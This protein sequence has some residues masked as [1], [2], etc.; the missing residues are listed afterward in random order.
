[1]AVSS[2]NNF[3]VWNGTASQNGLLMPKLKYRFRVLFQGF[4]AGGDLTELTKQVID[5]KR[6]SVN[7]N[8]ITMDVYNSKVYLQGKPEWQETT[9][10][11]RDDATGIVSKLVGQQIQKQFDFAEQ[12]SAASG[13]D[14]KFQLQYEVLDGSNGAYTAVTS[15]ILETWQ[16]FGCF[17][18]QVD[19]GDNNYGTNDPMTV[20]LTIRYDNALQTGS[21]G[22]GQRII[23]SVIQTVTGGGVL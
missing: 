21:S 1:M 4:G 12:A 11:L 16:L 2:L 20:A 22:I 17:I 19:Y 15:G 13:G 18:S 8:P 9:I 10:N 5:I 23:R 3:T 14:Y 7:F 6:P